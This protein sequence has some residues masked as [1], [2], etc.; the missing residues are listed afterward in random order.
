MSNHN[1]ANRPANSAQN[2]SDQVM[3][4]LEQRDFE[5]LSALL[6]TPHPSD[7]AR[8]LEHLPEENRPRIWVEIDDNIRGEVLLELSDTIRDTIL[9]Q[10]AP[11]ELLLTTE[12]LDPDEQADLV[13]DL[14][15]EAIE[16]LLSAMRAHDRQRLEHIL[17]YPEDCAGGLM[18]TDPVSVRSDLNIDVVLRYLRRRGQIPQDTDKLIVI[19][20]DDRY[21]GV[22]ALTELLTQRPQT[23]ISELMSTDL[24]AIPVE[25]SAREVAQL[26]EDRD[27]ISAPVI[28]ATGTLVGRITIDDVVDVLRSEADHSF[29]GMAGLAE[30]EDLFTPVM[31]GT[32]RRTVWL[33]VNLVTAFL[34]SWVIGQFEQTIEKM[35]ALAV[36]MPIVA[37]MGGNAGGQSLALAIRGLALGQV[38]RHNL[39]G[40]LLKETQIGLLGG[41]IWGLVVAVA[42][43]LWFQDY[44]LSLVIAAAMLINLVCAAAGGFLIPVVLRRLGADPALAS[45]VVL[46]T[47]TDVV[48]FWS[49][50]GLA[51]LFLI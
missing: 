22:V 49:F 7:L 11:Q 19:D 18:N 46:T 29:M 8:V 37:S 4:A 17:S 15:D 35:V 42:V 2:L 5:Q 33:A 50:L 27:L 12:K 13:A 48:G 10:M 28:D 45:T 34:A 21:I 31:R 41:L 14:P 40:L 36:L 51:T 30:D 38:T 9:E 24:P 47:F 32:R 43:A 25:T 1:E 26:F 16:Q 20:R 3:A 6:E 44:R 23:A 39:R